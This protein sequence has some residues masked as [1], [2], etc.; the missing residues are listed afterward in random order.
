MLI[1]KSIL[2]KSGLFDENYFMYSEEVELTYRMHL[3]DPQ[4]QTWYLIG[5]Q[6]IHLGGASAKNK[7]DPI[8]NEYLGILSFFKKHKPKYQYQIAKFLIK[9]NAISRSVIYFIRGNKNTA[10]IYLQTCSKI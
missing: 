8:L 2:D 3:A 10:S 9:I 1:R 5:P 4:G 6:I 7:I